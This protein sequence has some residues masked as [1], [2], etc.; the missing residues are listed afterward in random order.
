MNRPNDKATKADWKAYADHL[1]AK[2]DALG[3]YADHLEAKAAAPPKAPAGD[4]ELIK[5]LKRRIHQLT[6]GKE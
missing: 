5:Q 1:E 6:G 4:S 3:A 2:A